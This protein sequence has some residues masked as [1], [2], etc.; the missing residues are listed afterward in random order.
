MLLTLADAPRSDD[1]IAEAVMMD[2]RRSINNALHLKMEQD[3]RIYLMGEDIG[4][5]GGF[6]G[7]TAELQA[8]FGPQRVMDSP[9]SET[10]LVGAAIGMAVYG[11]RPV[12]EIVFMDFI[13]PAADQIINEL[14]KLRFRSGGQ[15]TAPVVIRAPY[16][17]GIGG[18][19]YHSQSCEAMFLHVPGLKVVTPSTPCDAKGLLISAMEDE[20]PV[21]FLE[22]K[23]LYTLGAEEVPAGLYRVP[24]G[25]ARVARSGRDITLIGYGAMV[26]VA[27]EAAAIAIDRQIDCEVIDLRTLNPWDEAI[28]LNL[29]PGRAGPRSYTKLR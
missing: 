9:L 6:F 5:M 27:L 11:L 25:Q 18:G 7:V 29:W 14:A 21:L 22:P 15:F 16:G 10:A 19:L 4:T 20:D 28:V 2:M 24:L 12:V 17:G 1:R 13:Y 8:R 26:P 23:R 3:D